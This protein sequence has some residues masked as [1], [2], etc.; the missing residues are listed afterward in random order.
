[1]EISP[2]RHRE[3]PLPGGGRATGTEGGGLTPCVALV[4]TG[5]KEVVG[6]VTRGDTLFSSPWIRTEFCS[7]AVSLESFHY[8]DTKTPLQ[9]FMVSA[10]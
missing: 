8:E 7:F 4:Y 6:Q 2:D 3:R 10:T 1:M 9:S 5:E